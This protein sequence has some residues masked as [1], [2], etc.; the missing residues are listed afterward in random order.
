MSDKTCD[1]LEACC[2]SL[3]DAIG[4]A[5]LMQL[6]AIKSAGDVAC[7]AAYSAYPQLGCN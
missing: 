3:D 1:D 6:N 5:C 4:D 2:N 7:G